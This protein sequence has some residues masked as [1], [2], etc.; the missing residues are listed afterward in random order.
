MYGLDPVTRQC[1]YSTPC[2][3]CTKWDKQCDKKVHCNHKWKSTG[4][5]GGSISTDRSSGYTI[6]QC[7]KCGETKEVWD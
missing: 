2:N 3:W 1:V 6:Y 4:R 5:G 7:E